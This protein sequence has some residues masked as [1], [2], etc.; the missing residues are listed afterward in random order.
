MQEF[1]WILKYLEIL[2]IGGNIIPDVTNSHNIKPTDF[3]FAEINANTVRA[4]V[5][6]NVTGTVTGRSGSTDKLASRTT[7]TFSGDVTA[8]MLCYF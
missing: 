4:N 1:V 7:F 3:K 6:G 2:P 8:P 5:V